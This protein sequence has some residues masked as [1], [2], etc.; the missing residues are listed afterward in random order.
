M[1]NLKGDDRRRKENTRRANKRM[2]SASVGTIGVGIVVARVGGA[3]DDAL[4]N[5]EFPS[6]LACYQLPIVWY[7][8]SILR[9]HNRLLFQKRF[10]WPQLMTTA[11]RTPLAGE[12]HPTA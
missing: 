8:C 2:E 12:R 9:P 11:S 10:H 5:L 7:Y 4:N 3:H 1:P 6:T